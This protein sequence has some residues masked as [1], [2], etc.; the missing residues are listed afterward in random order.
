MNSHS[1]SFVKCPPDRVGSEA[2]RVGSEADAVLSN[3]RDNFRQISNK[4]SS[5][6]KNK[7]FKSE[8]IIDSSKVSKIF[9]D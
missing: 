8:H 2:D 6:E 4:G 5:I 1:S 9:N 7:E 3:M